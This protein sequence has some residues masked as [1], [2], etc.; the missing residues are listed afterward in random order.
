MAMDTM[1][2]ID[3]RHER[4]PTEAEEL[5]IKEIIRH[6]LE[7]SRLDE[8]YTV[9]ASSDCLDIYEGYIIACPTE[10]LITVSHKLLPSEEPYFF[11]YEDEAKYEAD[12]EEWASKVICTNIYRM[13]MDTKELLRKLLL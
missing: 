5:V 9:Y 6:L 1:L 13:Q 8:T 7:S 12:H 11:N 4:E 2:G 10:V 3:M